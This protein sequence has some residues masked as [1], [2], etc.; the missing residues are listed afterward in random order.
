MICYSCLTTL[1][2][3]T[4]SP[5]MGFETKRRYTRR[6]PL[7]MCFCVSFPALV[8]FCLWAAA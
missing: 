8:G 7:S 5:H 6:P 2:T 4:K 3:S 1:N